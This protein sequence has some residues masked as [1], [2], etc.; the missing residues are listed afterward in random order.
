MKHLAQIQ[1]EFLRIAKAIE[2]MDDEEFREYREKYEERGSDPQQIGN[3]L[4]D[5]DLGIERKN[6]KT[7]T[8]D[9]KLLKALIQYEK[10]LI[11]KDVTQA[12][13]QSLRQQWHKRL[14]DEFG[15]NNPE[16]FENDVKRR[17]NFDQTIVRS[18]G[19]DDEDVKEL[20]PDIKLDDDITFIP[21]DE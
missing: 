20:F 18:L 16:E 19:K 14:T 4:Q 21:D 7:P 11:Q 1:C 13:K 15:W 5:L 17:E 3:Y 8:T 10:S 2:D 9:P 12:Q 6:K